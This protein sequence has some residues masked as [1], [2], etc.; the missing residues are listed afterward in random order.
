[1]IRLKIQE[2]A[3]QKGIGQNKLARLAD[4]DYQ[5]VRKIYRDPYQIINTE[6][7]NK[8]AEALHVDASLL[9]ESDPPLPKTLEN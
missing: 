9:I 1:M 5:T 4:V 3:Q 6:T 7:L 2:I 8:L